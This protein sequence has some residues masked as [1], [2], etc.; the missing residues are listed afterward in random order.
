MVKPATIGLRCAFDTR[1]SVARPGPLLDRPPGSEFVRDREGQLQ[2]TV[3]AA[4]V[5]SFDLEP[6]RAVLEQRGTPSVGQVEAVEAG[7][8][9]SVLPSAGGID[10][11]EVFGRQQLLAEVD[12][13]ALRPNGA[14]AA[15]H[16]PAKPGWRHWEPVPRWRHL[17]GRHLVCLG[18]HVHRPEDRCRRKHAA[19][20]REDDS[21][22][23]RLRRVAPRGQRSRPQRIAIDTGS[24]LGEV[25][26]KPRCS[27]MTDDLMPID[28]A[29]GGVPPARCASAKGNLAIKHRQRL[30]P[31]QMHDATA[32]GVHRRCVRGRDVDP[33]MERSRAARDTRVVEI[34]AHRVRPAT[35]G[36]VIPNVWLGQCGIGLVPSQVGDASQS[37]STHERACVVPSRGH[38]RQHRPCL[39]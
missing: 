32:H 29:G 5:G 36:N 34:A 35:S 26:M 21:C 15:T 38:L 12:R 33:E 14:I 24:A 20:A 11:P 10:P 27:D 19:V 3:V 18:D 13:G 8:P 4:E 23:P 37:T 6:V 2:P 17:A 1:R 25:H 16:P 9:L 28:F 31:V 7:F 22:Y 30:R 39:G